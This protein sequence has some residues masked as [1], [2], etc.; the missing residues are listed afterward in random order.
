MARMHSRKKGT[1]SSTHPVE[2]TH[3]EWSMNAT[4]IEKRIVELAREGQPPAQIGI[5]LRDSYGV[6]DVRA[7]LGKKMSDVLAEH[8]LQGD[9][10]EDLENLMVK[11]ENLREHLAENSRDIENRRNLYL[12][13]AKIRRLLKYYKREGVI[14]PDFRL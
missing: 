7:A 8:D 5:T 3:P 2:R 12:I 14:S 10:P 1:A 11:R 9:M 4:D 6:P 13:E